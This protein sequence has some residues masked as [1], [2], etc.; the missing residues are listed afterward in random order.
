M[1]LQCHITTY[2]FISWGLRCSDEGK[3][4]AVQVTP[5]QDHLDTSIDVCVAGGLY[6]IK[7]WMLKADYCWFVHPTGL[8]DPASMPTF[9]WPDT[10]YDIALAKEV[11]SSRPTKPVDWDLIA[12]NLNTV[13]SSENVQVS[14]K[15]RGCKERMERLLNKYRTDDTASIRRYVWVCARTYIIHRYIDVCVHVLEEGWRVPIVD[16][17]LTLYC[18]MRRRGTEEEYY[19]LS[20]LLADISSYMGDLASLQRRVREAKSK[21]DKQKSKEIKAVMERLLT[22]SMLYDA[23]VVSKALLHGMYLVPSDIRKNTLLSAY[24]YS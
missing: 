12:N 17:W 21:E 15:G 4:P 16:T 23:S 2:Q 5:C 22:S 24:S 1:V 10:S 6:N 19:E 8:F 11:V 20:Q 13:F 14:L 3:T 18:I 9:R 7:A